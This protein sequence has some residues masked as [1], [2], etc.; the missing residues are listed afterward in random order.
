MIE[1]LPREAQELRPEPQQPT[2][3][4]RELDHRRSDGIS[5]TLLWS[6]VTK[7]VFI[8][9]VEEREG[10]SF[11]FEVSPADALDAFRHPFAYAA[12]GQSQPA[13]AA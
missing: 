10:T 12:H 7:G 2:V 9:V 5:V 8:S 1:S 11:Q 4:I 13:L 6:V 3:L